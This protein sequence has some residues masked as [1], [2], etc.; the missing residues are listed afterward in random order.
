MRAQI[1]FFF[2]I[3]SIVISC[4]STT[5]RGLSSR[6]TIQSDP[7]VQGFSRLATAS[8]S[9]AVDQVVGERGFMSHEIK[10]V[11]R[12]RLCGRAVTVLAQPSAESQPP[13]MAL[14]VIDTAEPG[15]ILVIVMDGADGADIAAFGGIMCTGAVARGLGGAVFDGGCRDVAE[16]E[17]MN[18]PVF[19]RGI[20]PSTS[21]GRYINVSSNE[22]VL[23]GDVEVE[24]GD[25]LVGDADGVVVVPHEHA[26]AVLRRA[27][28]LEAQEAETAQKVKELKS[29]RKAI[30]ATRRI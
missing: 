13:A 21:V 28:E 4:T 3:I 20:V 26:A 5:T 27:Q 15:S 7:L 2:C 1:F 30:E 22:P 11:F 14:E 10:P 23:C 24:P 18:F 17:A 19:A 29:V 8:V 6:S 12:T 25:I 9:D 16:I